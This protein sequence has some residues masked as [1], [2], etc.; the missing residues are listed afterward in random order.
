MNISPLRYPGGKTR[1][2][3]IL[4]EVIT[5]KIDITKF[6][7]IKSPFFGGGS[8][9]FYI[10]NK[11]NL[12]II[13]NDKFKPLYNFWLSCKKNKEKLCKN[14][15]KNN[16]IEKDYFYQ[17]REKIIDEKRKLKQA[18]YYF[19][20]NRCSFSGSTLSGGFSQDASKKR[21]TKSSIDRINNLDLTNFSISNLDFEDFLN[22]RHSNSLL[23]L[24]PPYYLEKKSKLY[25]KDGDMHYDFDH[26][27]L[28]N[29]LKNKNNWILTY[30]NCSFIK[31]MYK[32]YEIIETSWK[33]GM[34]K[35]KESSEL[36]IL[37]L[38]NNIKN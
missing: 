22:K 11:Y 25:G 7:N 36:I 27:K 9:E 14:L 29:I 3:K 4:D 1:A 8:F 5:N 6:K 24:D 28:Y 21:Y 16:T 15:H 13:A 20:I 23:F 12:N 35:S 17:I 33:Y 32:D 18:E 34:N 38:I 30:N 2:C 37:N 26:N 19:I 31:D 10:Q